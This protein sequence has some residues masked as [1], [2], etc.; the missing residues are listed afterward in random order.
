MLGHPG[1]ARLTALLKDN[2]PGLE[3]SKTVRPYD[4][5]FLCE[6]CPQG[7]ARRAF[8]PSTDR[9]A[10]EPAV[11][12]VDLSGKVNTLFISGCSYFMVARDEATEFCCAYLLKSKTEVCQALADLII[13]FEVKSGNQV[14][15]LHPGNGSEFVNNKTKLPF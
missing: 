12:H 5:Q 1:P 4:V 7:K 3:V 10:N 8:H 15:E 11:R 2:A 13:Q 14:R 6:Q 9:T